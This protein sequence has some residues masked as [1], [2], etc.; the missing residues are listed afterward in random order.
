M[1]DLL[2]NHLKS[3]GTEHSSLQLLVNQWGFD[4]QLIPKAL[5]SIGVLFPHYSRHDESHSKQILVNIERLLGDNIRLLTASDTWLILES[6]YWHDIG[7]V[8][9]QADL[10]S[11]WESEEF[12]EYIEEIRRNP[13]H[14][15]CGFAKK[16][17][18]HD[19]SRSLDVTDSPITTVSKFRELMAEWFRRQHPKRADTIVKSPWESAGISSPRT[20]LIPARL[21]KV[22]GNICRMH[23]APFNEILSEKGL[24]FRETGL[25]QEDCHPRFVACLLRMGDLLDLDDNR[26]CPVMQRI[27]GENRPAHSRAHEDKHAAINHLRIDSE[28]IEISAECETIDGYIESFKWFE[29]LRKE[30]QDQMANWRDIVPNRE[31]GLLPTLGPVKLSLLGDTQILSKGERPQFSIDGAQAI[32]LL[33]GSNLYETHYAFVRELIQNAVDA[34]LINVWIKEKDIN[35]PETWKS[36]EA[37]REVLSKY[38]IYVE[39]KEALPQKNTPEEKS[40]W[41]L[42]IADSGTG[43]SI[44]DLRYMI[45]I[46]SSQKNIKRQR[47]INSM[48]EWMKPSGAFG[49]GLQSTFLFTESIKI[50]TKSAFSNKS[51]NITMHSPTEKYEGLVQVELLNDE[52]SRPSGTELE[53][54]FEIDKKPKFWSYST[55]ASVSSKLAFSS[56]PLLDESYPIQAAQVAD[57][58]SEFS[59]RSPININATFQQKKSVPIVI[60]PDF[61]D[62]PIGITPSSFLR[63]ENHEIEISYAPSLEY[64]SSRDNKFYYRGQQFEC[65]SMHVPHVKVI[66]NLMSGRAGAWLNASRDSIASHA[67]MEFSEIIIKALKKKIKNDLDDME[68]R[69]S[70]S[71][72]QYVGALSMFLEIMAGSNE[73]HEWGELAKVLDGKWKSITYEGRSLEQILLAKEPVISFRTAYSRT[74]KKG[75]TIF[76]SDWRYYFLDVI[77]DHWLNSSSLN[78]I[79][80]ESN[81]PKGR[82]FDKAL[83]EDIKIR[84]YNSL[85]GIYLNPTY[86]LSRGPAPAFREDAL[87]CALVNAIFSSG[88]NSRYLLP[89]PEGKWSHLHLKDSSS[90]QAFNLFDY[91]RVSTPLVLVPFLFRGRFRK[92]QCACELTDDQLDGIALKTIG[93]LSR[94]ISFEKAKDEYRKL[95]QEIDDVMMKSYFSESWLLARNTREV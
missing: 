79:T 74:S 22:L 85:R 15:L 3:K 92:E 70:I 66:A 88:A 20:E 31:L 60:E 53:I 28:R 76:P 68:V 23:G 40:N 46:G 91:H 2:I 87:Q 33:Q 34:T 81:L 14:N 64:R 19:I 18:T 45:K 10:L 58:I 35:P 5:Q 29:W 49:I 17:K 55:N 43:I 56:D 71:D 47:I 37:A 48:P 24:P 30:I 8:V 86:R 75:Q 36:P 38:P 95:A 4:E 69:K 32:T 7:M 82:H 6:A 57:N 80:I 72:G 44:E 50:N 65:K 93:L 41:S 78:A 21:F 90:I 12:Q 1:A 77:L 13:N 63:V 26:F 61:R 59:K 9:P 39:L 25:A 89:D 83:L 84:D 27:S 62:V 16:I 54:A 73:D 51:L 52:I 42:R 11:A 67:E 94:P